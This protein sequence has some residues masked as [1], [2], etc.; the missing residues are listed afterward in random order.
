[1]CVS[2]YTCSRII[3]RFSSKESN[4]RYLPRHVF[5]ISN[6][7]KTFTELT[8]GVRQTDI[9]HNYSFYCTKCLLD[10]IIRPDTCADPECFVRGGPTLTFFK[11][12][13]G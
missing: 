10:N 3:V 12:M 1:M 8:E 7:D 4:L 13:R 9:G 11:L 6:A 2:I 5:E